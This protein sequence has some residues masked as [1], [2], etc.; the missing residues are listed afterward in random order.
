MQFGVVLTM[1]LTLLV[2][3]AT[4]HLEDADLVMATLCYHSSQHRSTCDQRRTELHGFAC[5]HCEHLIQSDFGANV[6][7]YLFYFEFFASSNFVLFAAGFYD[8]VHVKPH[9]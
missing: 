1:A 8:R 4:T 2:V 9:E 3:L 5:A 6:S 7:R